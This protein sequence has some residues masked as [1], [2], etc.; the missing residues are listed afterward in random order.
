MRA[1]L[2]CLKRLATAM[3]RKGDLFS[4]TQSLVVASRC[5]QMEGLGEP[6]PS[7]A[8]K[9]LADRLGFLIMIEV[10]SPNC[11]MDS[12]NASMGQ[13]RA[14]RLFVGDVSVLTTCVPP[15]PGRSQ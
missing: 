10:G 3:Q 7:L 6:K 4:N 14:V 1:F 13:E 12:P 9:F 5:H 15:Y 2:S 11:P 8:R